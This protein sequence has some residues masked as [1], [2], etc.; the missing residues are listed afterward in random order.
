MGL[1]C[2][3]NLGP[4]AQQRTVPTARPIGAFPLAVPG[5]ARDLLRP[6]TLRTSNG[7]S[8][9]AWVVRR[10]GQADEL[11]CAESRRQQAAPS[12]MRPVL[13]VGAEAASQI[14]W[15]YGFMRH[16]LHLHARS[17]HMPKYMPTLCAKAEHGRRT[18]AKS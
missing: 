7:P 9:E 12:R 14:G 18:M 5:T 10:S 8:W 13:R 3:A 16:L 6:A 15:E 4:S 2:L 1:Y 11:A 17:T